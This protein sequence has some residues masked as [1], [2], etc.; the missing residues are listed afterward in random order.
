M[1]VMLNVVGVK[2]NAS[3]LVLLLFKV[4]EVAGILDSKHRCGPVINDPSSLIPCGMIL[5]QTQNAIGNVDRL[6]Q[7]V[8]HH[9]DGVGSFLTPLYVIQVLL[10]QLQQHQLQL[11]PRCLVERP[12]RFVQ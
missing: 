9:H 8:R 1:L 4:C 11:F 3:D 2:D 5:R 12:E 6:I 10:V 7:L